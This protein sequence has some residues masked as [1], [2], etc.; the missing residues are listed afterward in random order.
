MCVRAPVPVSVFVSV[1]VSAS[2][3]VS[4]SEWLALYPQHNGNTI[5]RH[6]LRHIEDKELF[7]SSMIILERDFSLDKTTISP[8]YM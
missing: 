3:S 4:V 7:V 5:L 1:S 6:D 8:D 2:L